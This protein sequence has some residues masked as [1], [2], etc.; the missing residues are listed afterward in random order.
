MAVPMSG[1]KEVTQEVLNRPGRFQKVDG[2]LDVKEVWLEEE[3]K[4]YILCH[5]PEE[6][7][8]TKAHRDALLEDLKEKLVSNDMKYYGI[9]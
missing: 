5:N 3:G 2:H 6:V 1:L 9:G 4:R 7:A 8:R